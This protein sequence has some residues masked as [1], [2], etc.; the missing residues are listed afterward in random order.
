M[1]FPN[2]FLPI[3]RHTINTLYRQPVSSCSVSRD[4]IKAISRITAMAHSKPQLFS[5]TFYTP[6]KTDG[7]AKA[8]PCLHEHCRVVTEEGVANSITA[9]CCFCCIP[10]HSLYSFRKRT[11]CSIFSCPSIAAHILSAI[12]GGKL[13]RM[14]SFCISIVGNSSYW[15]LQ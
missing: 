1:F 4:T 9:A 5:F 11:K 10:I 15:M 14:I 12:C 2:L 3:Y 6:L 8:V 7:T 13:D